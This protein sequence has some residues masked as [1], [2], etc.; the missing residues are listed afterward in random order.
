MRNNPCKALCSRRAKQ[1]TS[2]LPRGQRI[3][4]DFIGEIANFKFSSFFFSRLNQSKYNL[5]NGRIN[6]PKKNK[7]HY[8][9]T[10]ERQVFYMKTSDLNVPLG[11]VPF[12]SYSKSYLVLW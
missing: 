12:H 4:R 7:M 5:F 1:S 8:N 3:I 2:A 9:F 10:Y 11:S 6:Y